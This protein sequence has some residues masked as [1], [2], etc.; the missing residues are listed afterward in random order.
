MSALPVTAGA[1]AAAAGVAAMI[2]ATASDAVSAAPRRLLAR[3]AHRRRRAARHGG[4]P[5]GLAVSPMNPLPREVWDRRLSYAAYLA[6]V[7]RNRPMFDEVYRQP[8]HTS[9]DV[10]WLRQL[11]PLRL[12]AIGEDWCPDVFHTLPTWARLVEEL[13]GWELGVFARDTIPDRMDAFLWRGERRRIPVYAF[14]QGVN[15]Q[16]WWSGRGAAAEAALTDFLGG[17]AFG[18][19]DD[20]ER[21]RGSLILQ[22]GYRREFRRQTLEEILQLLGA[23]FHLAAPS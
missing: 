23:F 7:A 8:S 9:A 13:P 18:A 2:A 4:Q 15:L 10:A 19:L 20:E 17:R 11:P 1:L 22:E 3:L 21:R 6:T 16:V 14:Y 5:S 12:L